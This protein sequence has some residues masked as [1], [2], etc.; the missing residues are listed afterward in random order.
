MNK[1][2]PVTSGFA[3]PSGQPHYKITTVPMVSSTDCCSAN[4]YVIPVTPA[5]AMAAARLRHAA[6]EIAL[7]TAA[8]E[9]VVRERKCRT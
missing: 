2:L 9:D 6:V 8:V 1:P 7:M 3:L 4:V 5:A